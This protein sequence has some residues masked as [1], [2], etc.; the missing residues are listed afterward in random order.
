VDSGLPAI[1]RV[2]AFVGKEMQGA[3]SGLQIAR[4]FWGADAELRFDQRGVDPLGITQIF[5]DPETGRALL[6]G[7]QVETEGFRFA[8]DRARVGQRVDTIMARLEQ[9]DGRRHWYEA[10]FLRYLIESRCAA[11]GISGYDARFGADLFAAAIGHQGFAPQVKRLARF[12][13][14]EVLTNLFAAVRDQ[15]LSQHPLMTPDRVRR[16]ATQLS[17]DSF[18]QV[19]S[20]ALKEIRQHEALAAY[21]ESSIMHSLT[22][23]LK[24]LVTQVGQGDERQLLAH[25]KL[26]LQFGDDAD[27]TIT[28]C[29]AGAHGDGTTRGVFDNWGAVKTLVDCGFIGVCPNAEEDEAIRRFWA[30]SERHAAWRALDPRDLAALAAIAADLSPTRTGAR[31]APV[32]TRILFAQDAVE[33]EPFALYDIASDI[34]AVRRRSFGTAD[35][36]VLGWML[37]SL[38]VADATTGA[39]PVLKRLRDAYYALDPTAEGSLAPDARLAEQVYRLSAPLC[40]DGC[41][42]CVHQASDLMSDS[43]T[44]ASTSRWLLQQFLASED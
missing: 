23:R 31:L 22:I 11:L 21:V 40:G 4:V 14:G 5:T 44:Q 39:A 8:L 13:S 6:H 29:E 34:E 15:L 10:Q 38:A 25:S 28:I 3:A 37:A 32:L 18:H 9:D 42:S 20:V 19:L 41:R 35:Q 2:D 33:A 12:W 17:G 1:E 24:M 27:P 43:L 7:Y 26:P 16:A 30:A 36:P